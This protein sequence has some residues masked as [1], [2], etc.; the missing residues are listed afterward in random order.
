MAGLAVFGLGALA[1]AGDKK[2]VER[3]IAAHGDGLVRADGG[4][5]EGE[6]FHGDLEVAVAL[7]N[8]HGERQFLR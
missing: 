3:G 7:Q 2:V 8:Q 6:V 4:L 5:P 1:F